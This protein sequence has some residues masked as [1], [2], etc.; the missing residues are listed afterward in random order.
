MGRVRSV[1]RRIR[2][3]ASERRR[4][5]WRVYKSVMLKPGPSLANSGHMTVVLGRKAG[6]YCVHAL[7]LLAFVGPRPKGKETLHLNHTPADNRL[8]NL[9][10]GTRSENL[11]MDY[12]RGIARFKGARLFNGK[13][14]KT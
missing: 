14:V 11:K 4:A 13:R 6:S 3:Q 5:H 8:V 9:R 12:A 10:Y 2:A 1:Q 7:V